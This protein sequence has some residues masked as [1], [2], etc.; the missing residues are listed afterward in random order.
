VV[1]DVV[2]QAEGRVLDALD[3]VR[4]L[5][6]EDRGHGGHEE[7]GEEEHGPDPHFWLDPMRLA[8]LVDAVAD[9][10]AELDPGRGAIYRANA[11][12]YVDE[13]RALDDAYR[14][15][16]ASCR[17]RLIVVSHAAFGYLADAYGLRQEAISGIS[18]ESEPDPARLAELRLL[19]EE[20]GVTTIFTEGLVSPA[21]A[22]TLAREAGIDTAVL[23][24]LEGLTSRQLQA[25]E[26]YASV[27][28]RNLRALEAALG[29]S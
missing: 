15:G 23:N 21:V 1:E 12:T 5:P 4:A 18:P 9:A 16:L 14:A 25:G 26:D 7:Q 8:D 3:V 19:V 10:L 17:S 24:P 13:L 2:G 27:M 28:R 22:E 29:C 20:E 11:R 6:A